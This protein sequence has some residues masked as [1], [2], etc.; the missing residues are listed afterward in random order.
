M[1]ISDFLQ[2]A[3]YKLVGQRYAGFFNAAVDAVARE[4]N[5]ISLKPKNPGVLVIS[6][7]KSGTIYISDTLEKILKYPPIYISAQTFP[8]DVVWQKEIIKLNNGNL[9]SRGHIPPTPYNTYMLT[10]HLDKFVVHVRDPRQA[11]L[12]WVHH[13]DGLGSDER[14]LTLNMVRPF[15][16]KGYFSLD[17]EEKINWAIENHMKK[18]VAWIEGW[19]RVENAT[20]LFTNFKEMKEEPVSFFN[21]ILQFYGLSAPRELVERSVIRPRKGKLHFRKGR[22]NEWMEVFTA[23]QVEKSRLMIPQSLCDRFGWER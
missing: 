2:K 6:M 3:L 16:P 8:D 21:R 7:P 13:I 17:F 14:S 11:T 20:L 1:T 22:V 10:K 15:L 19:T 9:F 5:E 23:E 4:Y 18:L 12:S